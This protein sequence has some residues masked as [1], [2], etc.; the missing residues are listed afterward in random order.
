MA[1]FILRLE[2]RIL[3]DASAPAVI[4]DAVADSS[5]DTRNAE[6]AI[7]DS[8]SGD[9]G[10]DHSTQDASDGSSDAPVGDPTSAVQENQVNVLLVASN[11]DN[12]EQLANAAADNI[13][14]ILYDYNSTTLSD[15]Q[16]MI[17]D[18][19]AGAKADTISFAT[20]GQSGLF[21]LLADTYVS[22]DTLAANSDLVNFWSSV[23]SLMKDG[24]RVD[25]LGCFVGGIDGNDFGLIEN[26]NNTL[27]ASGNDINIAASDDLTG[28]LEGGNWILEVGNIDASTYFNADALSSWAAQLLSLTVS[29]TGDSGAGSFR[30]AIIDANASPGGDTVTITTTGFV[31]L[32]SDLPTIT[33]S[34]DFNNASGNPSD[35]NGSA[36]EL[37][38]SGETRVVE[39]NAPSG[40]VSFDRISFTSA[41]TGIL[42]Q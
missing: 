32:A 7:A 36:F 19:L 22:S 37:Y 40:N 2:D 6:Q 24:G 4:A 1:L 28:N 17:S 29:T 39:I 11:V 5:S 26:L 33:G 41:T 12:A 42:V 38:G 25:L 13:I 27:D 30:Q 35:P 18:A 20:E 34:I 14:T 15:L 16:T 31:S 23:G 3:F 9:D 10:S 21:H 8:L